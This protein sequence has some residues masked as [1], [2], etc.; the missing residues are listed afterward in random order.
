[1]L[2]T[3]A[4]ISIA[5]VG[6]FFAVFPTAMTATAAPAE[7]Y[8]DAQLRV[9][10]GL[11][12]RV[13]SIADAADEAA[14]KLVA[15][16]G[17]YL[18]GE[19]G[20]IAELTGRAGGLCAAAPIAG[21]QPLPKLQSR[22]VVFYSDYGLPQRSTDRR[23]SELCA[24][25][26]LVVAFASA[27]NPIFKEPLSANVRPIPIEI[28]LDSRLVESA[29]GARLIPTATPAV[30]IAQWTYA[31]E[32]IGACRRRN[33]QLAVYL[34]IFLDPGHRRLKRTAGM[35]FEP[36]LRPPPVARESTRRSFWRRSATR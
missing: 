17:I 26:A 35:L 29:A 24:S 15:G 6:V 30:A 11:E 10:R 9:V 1:M 19:P 23:W 18:A 8:L 21:N 12:T 36:N 25:D 20:M 3:I 33:R 2:R 14:A 31:A 13:S 7:D 28:P 27:K 34:S 32:L 22:D 5:V 4:G 16:G